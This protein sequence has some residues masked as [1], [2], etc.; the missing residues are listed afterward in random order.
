MF[1]I[2]SADIYI[3]NHKKLVTAPKVNESHS[4]GVDNQLIYRRGF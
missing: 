4:K 3:M 1:Y 2:C